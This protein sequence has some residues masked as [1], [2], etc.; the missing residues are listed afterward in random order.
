M[1]IKVV[2]KET[3]ALKEF[4][5]KEWAAVDLEHFSKDVD[6][7]TERYKILVLDRKNNIVGYLNLKIS[8]KVAKVR[9]LLVAKR[10][11]RQGI[12]K[13]LVLK[14]EKISIKSGAHKIWLE[15]GEGWTAAEFYKSLG[16]KITGKLKN[17]YFKR[18]FFIFTKFLS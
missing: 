16:Y 11:R 4:L 10:V 17:H 7:E 3:K 5:R 13:K 8:A 18:N 12:G 6:W 14:A 2:K 9:E 1:K 15:T